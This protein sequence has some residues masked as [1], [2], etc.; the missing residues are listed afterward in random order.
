[1]RDVNGQP[2]M[3]MRQFS[4]LSRA[5]GSHGRSAEWFDSANALWGPVGSDGYPRPVFDNDT[6]RIDHDVAEYWRSHNFDLR[7]YL[8]RNWSDIGP[9]LTDKLHFSAGDMDSFYMNLSMYRLE[10]FLRNTKN[11]AFVGDFRW[12][13]PMVGHTWMGVGYD[14]W[15]T[16]LLLQ[17]AA[18]IA[19]HAPVNEDPSRW[20]Y[21]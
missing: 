4:R 10:D 19:K 16:D 17:I 2:L 15:P 3:T 21:Q 11:P 8:E 5:L 12:G 13:R 18:N 7:D 6:G 9:R 20:K 14:P 1:M